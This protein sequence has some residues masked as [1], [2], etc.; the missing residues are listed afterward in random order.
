MP[1]KRYGKTNINCT[2]IG[3]FWICGVCNKPKGKTKKDCEQHQG[4]CLRIRKTFQIDL[5]F[6]IRHSENNTKELI[7][8]Y[9]GY[10]TCKR[11]NAYRHSRDSHPSLYPHNLEKGY[12]RKKRGTLSFKVFLFAN[13]YSSVLFCQFLEKKSNKVAIKNVQQEQESPPESADEQYAHSVQTPKIEPLPDTRDSFKNLTG[14]ESSVEINDVFGLSGSIDLSA[15]PMGQAKTSQ[16][17][18]V[19]VK[20]LPSSLATIQ[21]AASLSDTTATS[22]IR[23]TTE[24]SAVSLTKSTASIINPTV[25]LTP[26]CALKSFKYNFSKAMSSPI[27]LTTPATVTPTTTAT[28]VG[29][30]LAVN[31]TSVKSPTE[32]VERTVN[33]VNNNKILI[34]SVSRTINTSPV[35]S[36]SSINGNTANRLDNN[37]N[38]NGAVITTEKVK[39]NTEQR[40]YDHT[41]EI[42]VEKSNVNKTVLTPEQESPMKSA[43]EQFAHS[44][45]IP[46]ME[47][48]H[49]S[50]ENITEQEFS[51]EINGVSLSTQSP[52]HNDNVIVLTDEMDECLIGN[53][54]DMKPL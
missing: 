46:E 33:L 34:K 3:G 23:A 52:F 43:D 24:A 45:N 2:F 9:C 38:A 26:V 5:K 28:T 11:G 42:N 7:C 50:L 12:V 20:L 18:I 54:F 8:E 31:S 15:Q 44:V 4:S 47:L 53:K 1:R 16:N 40:N 48:L 19:Y 22:T 10:K 39:I 32:S 21:T 6:G 37:E 51:N 25:T 49:D 13:V 14:Q 29:S 35:R 27:V 36:T 17:Q 41:A 30:G